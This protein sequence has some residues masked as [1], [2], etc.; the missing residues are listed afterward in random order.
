MSATGQTKRALGTALQLWKRYPGGTPAGIIAALEQFVQEAAGVGAL[1]DFTFS[2]A[3]TPP[4]GS[5]NVRVN[6]ADQTLAT[7]LWI[8]HTTSDGI[9]LAAILPLITAG[10]VLYLQAKADSTF[11]QAYTTGVVTDYTDYTEIA[12]TW[13]SGE[14]PLNDLQKIVVGL[15]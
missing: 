7:A 5:G 8:S 15:L 10:Q 3:V 11:R 6:N 2:T 14:S 1:G 4:P 13:K 12:V 9:D